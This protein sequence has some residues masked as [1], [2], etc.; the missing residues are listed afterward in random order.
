MRQN[1][2]CPK[3]FSAVDTEQSFGGICVCKCGQVVHLDRR[4]KKKS[5]KTTSTNIWMYAIAVLFMAGT[6]QIVHWDTYSIAI[7][8]LKAKQYTKKASI[9]DLKKI[10]EICKFRA[11]LNCQEEALLALYEKEANAEYLI[12]AGE[13]QLLTD[14]YEAAVHSLG[15]AL[16]LK[17]KNEKLRY[18]YAKALMGFGDNLSAAKQLHYLVFKDRRSTNVKAAADYVNLLIESNDFRL[19]KK[20]I[21][22]T[23]LKAKHA[24]MFG[25]KQLKLVNKKIAASKVARGH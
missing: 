23:R 15:A 2:Y 25:H 24:N 8:P 1:Q 19:A 5:H 6:L 4:E 10:T 11:K 7:I 14:S 9:D 17:P 22:S 12:R 20:V 16:Q 13:I 21:V 18:N 3:C